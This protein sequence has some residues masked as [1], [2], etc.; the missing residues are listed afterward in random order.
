MKRSLLLS[1]FALAL[2]AT[3]A[4]AG[5]FYVG[6]CHANSFA[7]ISAAVNSSK[8]VS[9]STIKVCPGTYPEQI[10]ISKSLTL[11]GTTAETSGRTLDTAE[12]QIVQFSTPTTTANS[13]LFGNQLL[14]VVWV[15]AGVVNFSNIV[16]QSAITLNQSSTCPTLTGGIFYASGSSG[17]VNHSSIFSTGGCSVAIWAE[18]ASADSESIK[19]ENSLIE[20]D[21]RGIVALDAQET[22]NVSLLT[23]TITGN[24]ISN[25]I[26]GIY[27][28]NTRGTV[29]GNSIT[30]AITAEGFFDTAINLLTP[31]TAVT[32]NTIVLV[33]GVGIDMNSSGS[34]ITGNK[35]W[36]L[37]APTSNNLIGIDMECNAGTV[38]GNTISAFNGIFGA[39]KNFTGKNIFWTTGAQIL[40]GC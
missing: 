5:T 22:N 39:P 6:T 12:I 32:D 23:N 20:T 14:P 21:Y 28:L 16:I 40:S 19:I 30:N 36:A 38:T 2:I 18:N 17:T 34:T 33:G 27:L 1:L 4:V 26:I 24:Q 3:P 35:I 29:S 31:A 25:S 10:V 37:G 9:G 11:E 7:T 13:L 15:T 8:V